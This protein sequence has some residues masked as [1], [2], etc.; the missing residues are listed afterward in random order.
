M[1]EFVQR[2]VLCVSVCA[3]FVGPLFG[4]LGAYSLLHLAGNF[5]FLKAGCYEHGLRKPLVH[6]E[7]DE[8]EFLINL[9]WR[10]LLL[11]LG[12]FVEKITRR[13][14]KIIRWSG[15]RHQTH[16]SEID[17]HSWWI[18]SQRL[19]SG[20]KWKCHFQKFIKLNE[21]DF[22]MSRCNSHCNVPQYRMHH[23]FVL[24]KCDTLI[25]NYMMKAFSSL[26]EPAL[27]QR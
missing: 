7:H 15:N 27:S 18:H 10:L 8:I 24:I 23:L 17:L 2:Y 5:P 25:I 20:V 22:E 12:L 11:M 1:H 21:I 9:T 6:I 13:K 19:S 14:E 3:L 16:S 26:N 4:F